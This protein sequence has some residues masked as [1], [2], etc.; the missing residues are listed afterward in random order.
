MEALDLA[1]DHLAALG[2]KAGGRLVQH[3]HLRLHGED[4]GDGG[5]ALL[6]ARQ[7]KR[8]A[9]EHGVV[10]A[11]EMRRL[12]DA[13]G[14]FA[15]RQA[16]VARAEADVLAHRLLKQLVFRVLEH[17]AD[18]EAVLADFFGVGPDVGAVDEDF[19][20]RGPVEAV[21]M[22]DERRFAAAGGAD[23]AEEFP[24]LDAEADVVKRRCGVGHA[25]AVNIGQMFDL[26][27]I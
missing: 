11:A 4:A 6:P 17:H 26:N 15:F 21:E 7:L 2:V 5:A 14:D 10:K 16:H 23:D 9:V 12:D 20:R 13:R 27:H 24:A 19:A 1:E 3:Q 18:L 8:G 22:G 25:L